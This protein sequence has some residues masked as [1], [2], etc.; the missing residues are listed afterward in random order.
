MCRVSRQAKEGKVTGKETNASPESLP[1]YPHRGTRFLSYSVGN[2]E[3]KEQT[4]GKNE[5]NKAGGGG[6]NGI[7]GKKIEVA[8]HMD[9]GLSRKA[10]DKKQKKEKAHWC[11]KGGSVG[12]SKGK[13]ILGREKVP[14]GE[15]I[16][17]M[18]ERKV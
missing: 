11:L 17:G 9:A 1:E 13:E 7:A 14:E 12:V 5:V 2:R 4:Q 3:G 8:N 16:I 15:K 10:I 6:G 18:P